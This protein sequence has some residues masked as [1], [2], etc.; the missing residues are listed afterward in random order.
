[1]FSTN[2]G[3]KAQGKLIT[4]FTDLLTNLFPER[5]LKQQKM[6]LFLVSF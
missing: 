6:S 3:T 1:M 2:L 4:D 5:N